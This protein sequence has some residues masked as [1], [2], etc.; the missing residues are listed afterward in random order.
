MNKTLR[1]AALAAAA[2]LL[3]SGCGGP[4]DHAWVQG[5]VIKAGAAYKVP[6]DRS[7][8]VMF[9]PED[10]KGAGHVYS[11]TIDRENGSFTVPGPEG[12]GVP[13]GKY[14]VE[15]VENPRSG[16]LR[17]KEKIGRQP[18]NDDTDYLL[19]R[20]GI[21]GSPFV[22]DLDGVADLTIDLDRPGAPPAARSPS[23]VGSRGR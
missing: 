10:A 16:S 23:A 17:G 11:A 3:A 12:Y 18:V 15:V 2:C 6:G 8:R 14:R 22:F 1:A 4:R 20:F 7:L 13:Q 9:H 19:N 5:K 21:P